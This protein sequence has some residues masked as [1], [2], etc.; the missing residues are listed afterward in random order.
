MRNDVA[1][2]QEEKR[3]LEETIL[4]LQETL[5]KTETFVKTGHFDSGFD[6]DIDFGSSFADIQKMFPQT[7]GEV[8]PS[9]TEAG[10]ITLI[11]NRKEYTATEVYLMFKERSNI[12]QY[13]RTYEHSDDFQTSFMRDRC[14][15][16]G[17]L[18]LNHLSAE[19]T[20][21]AINEISTLGESKNISFKD[22]VT[23][24]SKIHAA[25]RDDGWQIPHITNATD[26]LCAKLK[27]SPEKMMREVDWSI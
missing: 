19:M 20:I 15:M 1:E 16:E 23:T 26:D 9:T 6:V 12:E 2:L 22:L 11:T 18:F 27:F 3:C 24:L 25:R 8:L 7:V 13:F 10:T 17:W 21:S 14:G 5:Y 4:L